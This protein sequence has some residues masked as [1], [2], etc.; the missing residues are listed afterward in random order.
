MITFPSTRDTINEIRDAIGR[1]VI[2]FTEVKEDCPACTLNPLTQKSLDPFCLVCSGEGYLTSYTETTI[3][4][5]ISH[6]PS[7]GLLWYGGGYII[8]GDCRVQIEYTE[9]NVEVINT[10]KYV[11]VDGKNYRIAHQTKRGVQEINRILLD[12]KEY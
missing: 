5:H 2:F 4:G 10:C 9:E 11:R 12:L 7:E 8:D 1:G 6:N 3:S